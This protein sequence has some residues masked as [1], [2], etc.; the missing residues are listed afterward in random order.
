[1]EVKILIDRMFYKDVA[2]VIESFLFVKCTKCKKKVLA[3]EHLEEVRGGFYCT[4][5][6]FSPLIR[7]CVC[8]KRMYDINESELSCFI[9]VSNYCRLYCN[10]CY[11]R[12]RTKL[13]TTEITD[14]PHLDLYWV[15]DMS[16]DLLDGLLSDFEME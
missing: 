10:L 1:M 15:I 9:C 11:F 3:E 5:C 6:S 12:K 2:G 4:R 16:I 8:C 14:I 7:T 13:I